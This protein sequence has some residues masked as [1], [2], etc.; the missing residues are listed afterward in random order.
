LGKRAAG[1]GLELRS[2]TPLMFDYI[3]GGRLRTLRICNVEPL[4]GGFKCNGYG[5]AKDVAALQYYT[6]NKTARI[7]M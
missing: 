4:F 2:A 3:I 6:Q 5:K 1:E 7:K